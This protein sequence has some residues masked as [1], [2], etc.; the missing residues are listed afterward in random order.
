MLFSLLDPQ[1]IFVLVIKNLV[2]NDLSVFDVDICPLC[3]VRQQIQNLKTPDL[4]SKGP[5]YFCFFIKALSALFVF[6]CIPS[7]L[8][9]GAGSQT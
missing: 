6:D 1:L 7:G 4:F 8:W 9:L 5:K 3:G 2:S